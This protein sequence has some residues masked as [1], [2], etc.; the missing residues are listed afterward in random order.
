MFARHGVRIEVMETPGSVF[1]LVE[2]VEGRA[3][4]AITLVDNVLAYREGR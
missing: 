3:D 4:L 1:Q 2:L